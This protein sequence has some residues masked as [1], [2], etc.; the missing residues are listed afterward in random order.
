MIIRNAVEVLANV[1]GEKSMGTLTDYVEKADEMTLHWESH[2]AVGNG[3]FPV[4]LTRDLCVEYN[5]PNGKLYSDDISEYAFSQLCAKVGVPSSYI[6]KC[7]KYSMSDLAVHNFHEWSRRIEDDQNL[8]VREY[9]GVVRAVLSDRYNIFNTASVI[10]NIAQAVNSRRYGGRYELNQIFMDTDKLHMRFVDFNNPI[11]TDGDEV[12]PGFTVSSS[13]VG[14]GSLNIKYFL[15]RFACRNGLVIIKKG[16]MLFRQTHLADFD[17]IGSTLFMK[18]L[19]NID[20]M[21]QY[22]ARQLLIAERKILTVEEM[23]Q[24]LLRAQQELHLGKGKAMENMENL[25]SYTYP[26][27]NILSFVNA[28]TENAQMYTLDTRI[29]HETWA[30][31]IL[32][33]I[34]A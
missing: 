23:Q 32:S 11:R 9:D 6:N 8:L 27:N 2:N 34:A 3:R 33:G 14:S 13:D 1:R 4:T 24:Y 28:I 15:Y 10:R 31:K 29:E 18:A 7:F 19:E 22:A 5:D 26:G 30:G 12:I 17:S 25:L 16:G 20:E 21:N